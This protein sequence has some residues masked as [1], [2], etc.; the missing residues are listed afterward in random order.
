MDDRI[1][2]TGWVDYRL[3]PTYM[4]LADICIIPQPSNSFI[5]TTMPNKMYEYMAMGKPVL[6]SDAKPM[7]R[8]IQECAS[9]EIFESGSEADFADKVVFMKNSKKKYGRNAR[10]AVATKY[11]WDES[12]KML[13]RLY[14]ILEQEIQK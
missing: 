12:S 3:F 5:D 7:K 4:T 11:N 8:V 9:G 6:A 1:E 10:K 2:F 14:E 13:I